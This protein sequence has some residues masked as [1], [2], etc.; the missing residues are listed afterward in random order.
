MARHIDGRDNAGCD[1]HRGLRLPVR[2]ER[3]RCLSVDDSNEA[4]MTNG[5]ALHSA[6]REGGFTL[7]ELL[8]A[9]TITMLIAGALAGVVQPARAAFDR[10]PAELELQQRGRTAIDVLS[11]ALRASVSR[12][13]GAGILEELTVAIPVHA[14]A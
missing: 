4:A 13:E 11:Q 9:M 1:R 8:I 14:A 12:L 7:I 6:K 2:R 5:P 10:V 3:R